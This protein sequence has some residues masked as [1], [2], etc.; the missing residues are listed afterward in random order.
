M[1]YI[2]NGYAYIASTVLLL[3]ACYNDPPR[4]D[5]ARDCL[6]DVVCYLHRFRREIQVV[7]ALT[8][9]PLGEETTEW[10]ADLANCLALHPRIPSSLTLNNLLPL[11]PDG[12]L[13]DDSTNYDPDLGRP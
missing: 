8:P 12:V 10:H 4:T 1:G 2:A 9:P 5:P 7:M 6:S 11:D 3:A 13:F